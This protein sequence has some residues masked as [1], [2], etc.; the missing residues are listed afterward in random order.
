MPQK[1]IVMMLDGISAE[2]FQT[3]RSRMPFIS[4]LADRGHYVQNL[5]SA[6]LGVSLA[7]RIGMMTGVPGAQSSIT[8]NT[9]WDGTTFRFP[10]PY[11]VRVKTLPEQAKEAGKDVAV[12]GFGMLRPESAHIFRAPWWVGPL[13]IRAR[14]TGPSGDVWMRIIAE[15]GEDQQRF[16]RIMSE[17]GLPSELAP[18]PMDPAPEKFLQYALM[19]DH[20]IFDWVGALAASEEAPD[21]IIT[22]LG[23]PDSAQHSHGYKS[24]YAHWA[25]AYADMLVG[26]VVQRLAAAGKLDEYNLAVMSDHGHSPITKAIYTNNLLPGVTCAPDGSMLHVVAKNDEEL[27]EVTDKLAE[28]GCEPWNNDHVPDDYK[29]QISVFAAPEGLEFIAKPVK[30]GDTEPVGEPEHLSSHGIRP[31]LPGDDRLCVFAGPNV[32]QGITTE[33]TALQV[34]PTFAA[35]LGLPLSVYPAEPIFQPVSQPA[36]AV[37]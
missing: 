15:R 12:V 32:P 36:E 37:S 26:K 25:I 31:G 16:K 2:Y 30:E 6:V 19:A 34:A 35:L 33:A 27:R 10:T 9:Y 24:E 5:H 1:L 13:I 3:E 17:A 11:D 20:R 28:F 8:G 21:L 23:L 14:D 7:G 22:E 18:M 4:A 29:D